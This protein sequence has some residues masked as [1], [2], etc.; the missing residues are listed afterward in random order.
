MASWGGDPSLLSASAGG[1]VMSCQAWQSPRIRGS[2]ERH[3]WYRKSTISRD[4][5]GTENRFRPCSRGPESYPKCIHILH[6]PWGGGREAAA[7]PS[8]SYH[9]YTFWIAFRSP[10]TWPKSVF[11]TI[12][13]SRNRRFSVPSVS[14]RAS[15]NPGTLPG[16]A[17]HRSK[18]CVRTE[19]FS[20]AR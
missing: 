9:V 7:T 8:K 1:M 16:L 19:Y 13:V 15:P 11:C 3:R 5:D 2:T 4:T 12:C 6:V 18:G 10:G 14:L 20:W 17:T